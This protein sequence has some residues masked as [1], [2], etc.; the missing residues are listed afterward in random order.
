MKTDAKNTYFYK[1]GNSL[2]YFTE[3]NQP[4]NV[5]ILMTKHYIL[6][7]GKTQFARKEIIKNTMKGF[8]SFMKENGVNLITVEEAIKKYS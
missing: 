1:E 6:G 2:F 3:V 8:I 4:G 7:G 5:H